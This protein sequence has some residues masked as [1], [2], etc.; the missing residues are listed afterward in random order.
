MPGMMDTILNLGLN[1]KSVLGLAKKTNNPR[2]AWDA[3]RRFIQMFGDVAMGVPH[4]EFE[5][6]LSEVKARAGKKLDNELDTSELQEI[7]AKYKAL[8]QKTT[9]TEFPRSTRFS[10]RG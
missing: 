8:Y 9:G 10:V 1:D 7:V 4:E 2:F 5:K 6:I 3:Y